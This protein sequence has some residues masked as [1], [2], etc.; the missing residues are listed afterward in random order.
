MTTVPEY[1]PSITF[2]QYPKDVPDHNSS[3]FYISLNKFYGY[4]STGYVDVEYQWDHEDGGEQLIYTGT[5]T[6]EELAELIKDGFTK[7]VCFFSR[8]GIP[9]GKFLW[10]YDHELEDVYV[11]TNPDEFEQESEDTDELEEILF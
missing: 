2:K 8:E 3:I 9:H 5:E 11:K 6:P 4:V 7:N 10:C 1:Q